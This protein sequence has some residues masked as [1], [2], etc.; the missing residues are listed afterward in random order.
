LSTRERLDSGQVADIIQQQFPDLA[1]VSVR[2]L[3]EG[4]DSTAFEV[5][6]LGIQWVF[7]FPKRDEVEQ[8]L[9]LEMRVLPVLAQRSPIPVPV[10]RFHGELSAAFPRRFGGYAKLAGVP[11]IGL[12]QA[13]LPFKTLAPELGRFLSWLH[14]FPAG[15]AARLGVQT[16][17]G[18]SFIDEVRADAL[19]DFQNVSRIAP[20]APVERWH[21][22]L[23]NGPEP[24]A[25]SLQPVLVH[26]DLA[27]EHILCDPAT[28][29]LTG[30]IDWSEM[31]LG[32]PSVDLAA[33][34][35]WG[36]RPF[37]DAALSTYQ[38]P[39]DD[40]TSRRAQFLAACR[41]V[42][43]V[44][45]G[46]EMDRPEYIRAGLRALTLCAECDASSGTAV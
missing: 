4:Y 39:V 30:V 29:T 10:F 21:G 31:A 6:A 45:F 9:L 41:G 42:G 2:H 18:A 5:R 44:T 27:A 28:I 24:A 35:H 14:A 8:Q 15:E 3:G 11:G 43:D 38:G 12:D 33:F 23:K 16:V 32:D 20:D 26:L 1:P 13:T 37:F 40:A 36:G 46:L 7:R 34:F 17:D 22:Y 19:D 25:S